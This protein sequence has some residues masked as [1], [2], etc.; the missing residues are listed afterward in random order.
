MS[1]STST[2]TEPVRGEASTRRLSSYR[3]STYRSTHRYL[4]LV[5]AVILAV[6][7]GLLASR[8]PILAVGLVFVVAGAL[9][10]SLVP[11]VAVVLLPLVPVVSGLARGVPIP[12]FRVSELLVVGVG[13][14]VIVRGRMEVNSYSP[15]WRA[16]DWAGFIYTAASIFVSL[17]DVYLGGLPA[18][19]SETQ[20][21]GPVQYFILY[22]AMVVC[23]DTT[24]RRRLALQSLLVSSTVTNVFALLQAVNVPGVRPFIDSLIGVDPYNTPG[25]EA[26]GRATGLFPI[27]HVLAGFDVAIVLI[28][29]ALLMNGQRILPTWLALTVAGLA[30]AG[31]A[32]SVTS[33]TAIGV[34]IGA[35]MIGALTG[36]LRQV[37]M[38]SFFSGVAVI[39]LIWPL[40]SARIAAQGYGDPNNG[41]S[42]V[43]QTLSY[44]WQV[45]TEQ[46]IPTISHR[47][48]SGWGPQLPVTITWP[49][50]ENV[51][52]SLLLRGGVIL[53]G[54]YLVWTAVLF[55]AAWRV[56]KSSP[57]APAD[58]LGRSIATALFALLVCLVVMQLLFPYMLTTGLPGMVWIMGAIV[59]RCYPS[60]PPTRFRPVVSAPGTIT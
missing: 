2:S 31:I 21:L 41:G 18:G 1:T 16:L 42:V 14:I 27:W 4:D 22:R 38:W 55:E 34:I 58:E 3:M 30:V 5:G 15:K 6:I 19:S 37:F 60:G 54:A 12:G 33:T 47:P 44:R 29:L 10:V 13:T 53:L 8:Q 48:V 32:A 50:P 17:G 23:L 25:Y 28:V 56:H 7:V 39:V 46:Y 26:V 20:I 35:L 59:I 52:L 49:Y 40:I 45:W 57:V 9:L 43:P 24:A 11:A 36:R 51:Y